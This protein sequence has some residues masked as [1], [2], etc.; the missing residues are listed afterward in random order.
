MCV[1]VCVCVCVCVCMC[2][3]YSL[4]HFCC[5]SF[6]TQSKER[7]IGRYTFNRSKTIKQHETTVRYVRFTCCALSSLAVSYGTIYGQLPQCEQRQLQDYRMKTN[8]WTL[9]MAWHCN[10]LNYLKILIH[11]S[12]TAMLSSLQVGYWSSDR[13]VSCYNVRILT[14]LFQS[15]DLINYPCVCVCVFACMYV[16]VCVC[17]CVYLC[18]CVYVCV[19][20]CVCVYLCVYM[21]E[22]VE[23]RG[24]CL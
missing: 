3:C 8:S 4:H 19:C 24:V 2:V 23:K 15:E 21:W 9:F 20:V 7:Q 6:Y 11:S 12:T 18:V 22:C 14:R 5:A 17:V 16:C 10:E 1:Y 13:Y